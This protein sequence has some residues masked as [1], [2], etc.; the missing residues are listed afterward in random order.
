MKRYTWLIALGIGFYF[1]SHGFLLSGCNELP[2]DSLPPLPK[3]Q[4]KAT[5]QDFLNNFPQASLPFTVFEESWYQ[6]KTQTI[7]V[8]YYDTFVVSKNGL[9]PDGKG[10][11]FA[12]YARIQ[13]D[14][15]FIPLIVVE[16]H[17]EGSDFWLITLNPKNYQVIDK[18]IIAFRRIG[19]DL[20]DTQIATIDKQW[21]I[22]AKRTIEKVYI[23]ETEVQAA[24]M[25]GAKSETMV[26]YKTWQVNDDG[27]IQ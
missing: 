9:F 5:F 27:T 11:S 21:R 14:F 22:K 1:L 10:R 23:P 25:G 16:E 8:A 19:K 18:E 3:L 26:Q 2:Q 7:G 24:L 13:G 17:K 20:M 4:E 12:F 15:A 6:E